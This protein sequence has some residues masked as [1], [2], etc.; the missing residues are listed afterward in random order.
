MLFSQVKLKKFNSVSE[1][2]FHIKSS[3]VDDVAIEIYI[4]Q[5]YIM[6]KSVY[7]SPEADKYLHGEFWLLVVIE[8]VVET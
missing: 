7:I 5:N 8:H 4:F 1:L 3:V 6:Q 2:F